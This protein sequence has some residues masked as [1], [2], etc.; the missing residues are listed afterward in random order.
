[1]R[2]NTTNVGP[3]TKP[4]PKAIPTKAIPLERFSREVTSAI[5]AVAT[6]RLPLAT[7]PIA[8]ESKSIQKCIRKNPQSVAHGGASQSDTKYF[9]SAKPVRQSSPN[10]SKKELKN[11]VER[12]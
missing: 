5:E 7:P 2:C 12:A 9:P 1:M 11:G 4:N 3:K 6:E 10:R 8:R